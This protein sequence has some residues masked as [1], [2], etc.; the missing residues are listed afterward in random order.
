MGKSTE[1]AGT[2]LMALLLAIIAAAFVPENV[3]AEEVIRSFD[4][5]VEIRN[6]GSQVVRE[7]I[8]VWA[9]GNRIRRG[10][11]R[12]LP[13]ASPGSRVKSSYQVLSVQ[14]DGK[15]H[16]KYAVED[17]SG[18]IRVRMGNPSVTLE[19]GEHTFVLEYATSGHLRFF[20]DS[21]EFGWNVTGDKWEFT[22][23]KAT[24]SVRLPA[25]GEVLEMIGWTGM[26]GS[27]DSSMVFSKPSPGVAH[28]TLE[29]PLRRG[30][31]FTVAVRF[32]H[33]IVIDP[34][35][36][37]II[38][39][40]S[41]LALTLLFYVVTWWIWGRDPKPGTIIPLFYPRWR[42]F[43]AGRSRT[44]ASSPASCRLLRHSM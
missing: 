8:T 7:T 24:C 1:P 16:A 43:T 27:R 42:D 2:L 29:K 44:G 32:P 33:G 36:G 15:A 21:D 35:E 22:I 40:I 23:E 41:V 37:Q 3:A 20:G 25:G 12:D 11:Y 18:G 9:E 26:V 28:F 17:I 4:S 14:I 19:R 10:I 39:V 31:H 34:H 30:R 5:Q 13:F 38:L 6:D